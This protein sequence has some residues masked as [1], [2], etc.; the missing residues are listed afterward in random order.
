MV[1]HTFLFNPAVKYMKNLLDSNTL[2]DVR[3][4]YC[5]RLNLGRIRS[6]VDA[7][8]NLAPHDLSIIDY[9]LESS[10]PTK[11]SIN[12]KDYV[13]KGINDV[14]FMNIN[15]S[16]GVMANIH[17]SWLDPH[18]T[19]KITVVCEKKMVVYDDV[20]K[21]KIV[22]FDKGIDKKAIL[23][24]NMEF[25]NPSGIFYENREGQI[26]IPKIDWEEPL[27]LEIQHFY[28]CVTGMATCI[29]GP[30]HAKAV[31]KILQGVVDDD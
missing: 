29:S 19:R 1:G 3:Y 15:Y 6:D 4:I 22:I 18:K 28:D 26:T 23:G 25:D 9:W 31:V 5:Q 13:Q 7:M 2:G 8:W 21:D 11:I 20:S 14:S 30:E 17:V 16:N 10:S 24:E 27:K 12:G